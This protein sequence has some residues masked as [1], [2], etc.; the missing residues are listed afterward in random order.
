MLLEHFLRARKYLDQHGLK[1][2][3]VIEIPLSE[4]DLNAFRCRNR[5][6]HA[7]RIAEALFGTWRWICVPPRR[8]RGFRVG[9][10]G[11][12][13]S[14]RSQDLEQRIWQPDCALP[15][16]EQRIMVRV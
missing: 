9:R 15:R 8:E 3:V 7:D 16:A 14:G 13:A 10:L 12:H 4:S 1:A 2:Q 11:L 6:P 5:F